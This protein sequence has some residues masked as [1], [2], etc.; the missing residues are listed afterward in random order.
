VF[1]LL[2]QKT[3]DSQTPF[4]A[5]SFFFSFSPSNGCT[6]HLCI[7]S[8]SPHFPSGSCEL[9]LKLPF[10]ASGPR[11][12]VRMMS[13]TGKTIDFAG[14][15]LVSCGCSSNA[16]FDRYSVRNLAKVN[17]KG[18]GRGHGACKLFC[19]T[20]RNTQCRVSCM[21]TAE[22]T[23]NGTRFDFDFMH[24]CLCKKLYSVNQSEAIPGMIFKFVVV[25]LNKLNNCNNCN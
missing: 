24:C 15:N 21:K 11:S 19:C 18:F 6:S 8:I 3:C 2:L 12:E 14:K 17:S 13:V 23:M 20:R 5:F 9:R 1:L 10:A 7:T 25:E 22:P 4:F 16:S